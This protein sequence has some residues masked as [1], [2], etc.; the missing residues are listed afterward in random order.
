MIDN[1][2]LQEETSPHAVQRHKQKR[3]NIFNI[4]IMSII[5]LTVATIV[6]VGLLLL[7][8][9]PGFNIDTNKYQAVFLTNGQ[10]YFG[11]VNSVNDDYLKL[12]NIFYLQTK[13][14][15]DSNNPQKTAEKNSSDVE[16]IKLGNEI[17]GPEDEMIISRDQILFYENLKNDGG[18]SKTISDYLNKE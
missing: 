11:K 17:H 4:M 7:K 5:V 12:V 14:Q 15:E 1:T 13:S 3:K 6:F 9:S 10:V 18:V 2:S 16:L 8:S